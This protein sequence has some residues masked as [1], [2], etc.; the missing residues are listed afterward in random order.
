ML[1]RRNIIGGAA[2]LPAIV[3]ASC[4]ATSAAA[5]TLSPD[6]AAVL[7][8]SA[9]ASAA[10]ARHDQHVHLPAKARASRAI[11][12]LPHTTV[13]A[14]PSLTGGQVVWSTEK[15]ST[16]AIARSIVDMAR[17]G[18]DLAGA[19]LTH[20]R[21]LTAAHLRRERAISRIM[22]DTG[23][24]AA[25]ELSDELGNECSAA[26]CDVASYPVNTAT[27]LAAKLAFMVKHQMGDGMDWLE[28]LHADAR[29]VA[30]LEDAA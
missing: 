11:E 27:D 24:S 21:A 7:D 20:A 9:Q 3:I 12:A 15:P 23:T 29:R 13:Y 5:E 14:G 26:Q 10:L 6:F 4:G 19:G 8:K 18:K 16:V 1:N 25:V 22:R 2:A 30:R 17:E 28:E